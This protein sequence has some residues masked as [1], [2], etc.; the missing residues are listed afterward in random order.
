MT[1]SHSKYRTAGFTFIELLMTVAIMMI[2]LGFGLVNYM[3]SLDKQKLYQIGAT[4]E[5]MLKDARSKAQNGFLGSEVLGFCTQLQGVEVASAVVDGDVQVTGRLR[6]SDATTITYETYAPELNNLVF[7]TQFQ[8]TFLAKQG[9]QVVLGATQVA[10]GA[11]TL[12][13]Q[14]GAVVFTLD[15]GGTINV[16]Y[17]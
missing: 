15:R 6:C 12:T 8:M 10:S 16:S 14:V 1:S 3:R 5:S 13:N 11:A 17:E 7:D 4:V 9:A 2:V